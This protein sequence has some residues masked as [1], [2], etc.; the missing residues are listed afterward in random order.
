ML[1]LDL[2]TILEAGLSSTN[3]GII[4]ITGPTPEYKF[5][6]IDQL[7]IMKWLY[8]YSDIKWYRVT[9]DNTQSNFCINKKWK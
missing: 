5:I 9:G 2:P 7:L 8:F 1:Q 6:N 3:N 4:Y